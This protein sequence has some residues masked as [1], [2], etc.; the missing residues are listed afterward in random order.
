VE[1][2]GA[3]ARL[4]IPVSED[5]HVGQRYPTRNSGTAGVLL[6]DGGHEQM[7]DKDHSVAFL[8]F[9]VDL[10]G[11]PVRVMLRIT[12]A[13]NPTGDA[14]RVCLAEG[15]WSETKVTYAN[16]PKAGRELARL[17]PMEEHDVVVRPLDLDL[18]GQRELSLVIDPTSTDGVDFLSRES[19]VPAELIVEYEE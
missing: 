13:G 19:G 4:T 3:R 17:G 16:R 6:L 9:R 18:A 8:K 1:H 11:K 14:G 12:N 15:D 5:A 10:P 7:N 2:L